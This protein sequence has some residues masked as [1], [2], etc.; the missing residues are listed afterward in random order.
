MHSSKSKRKAAW[1]FFSALPAAPGRVLAACAD[2]RMAGLQVDPTPTLVARRLLPGL[3]NKRCPAR[4]ARLAGGLEALAKAAPA[5]GR[6][7]PKSKSKI[8]G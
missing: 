3:T 7:A 8:H 2:D 5:A 4:V 6:M 1:S